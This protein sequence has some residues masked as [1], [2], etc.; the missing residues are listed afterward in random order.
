MQRGVSLIELMVGL[1]I[2][3]LLLGLGV[4]GFRTFLQNSQIRNAAEA[5]QNGLS[6]AK[7]EAVKRN[8]SIH[9]VLGTGTAWTV[10]TSASTTCPAAD[11][12]QA[13]PQSEGAKNAVLAV[14]EVV[15]STNAAATSPAFTTTLTFNGLG[16]VTT[17]PAG[18][19]AVFNISNTTGGDCVTAGGEMRCLRVVVTSAGQVRMCDPARPVTTPPDPQAC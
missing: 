4:P 8:T 1:A 11:V 7:I 18:N 19:N 15:A 16:R 13:R 12:I 9:F 17:I 5:I 10:C 6:L 14:S 3:G 2:M